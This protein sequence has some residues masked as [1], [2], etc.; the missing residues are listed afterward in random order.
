MAVKKVYAPPK[1]RR[2][3]RLAK[4]AEGAPGPITDGGMT[5]VAPP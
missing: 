1:V 2:R 4:A 3:Q 5:V